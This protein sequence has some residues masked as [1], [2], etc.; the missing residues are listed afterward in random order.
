MLKSTSIAAALILAAVSIHCGTSVKSQ[1]LKDDAGKVYGRYDTMSDGEAKALFDSNQNGVNERVSSYKDA[2]LTAVDYFDDKSGSKTK[3][4]SFKEGKPENVKIYGKD[5]KEVR[6]E[7]VI[8]AEKN[9][10]K[11]V[12]LPGKNKKVVFNADGTVSVSNLE[13]KK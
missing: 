5:G 9:T 8:D 12:T 1:Q 10:T 6:G 11:E 3:T 13:T 7:A 4:V 2:K